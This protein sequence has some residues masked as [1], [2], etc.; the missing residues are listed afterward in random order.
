MFIPELHTVL[1]I[2]NKLQLNLR[3]TKVE[4]EHEYTMY[5]Y[6]S[7]QS[8]HIIICYMAYIM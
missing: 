8:Q 6:S 2:K 3:P 4:T 7:A 5:L 1:V